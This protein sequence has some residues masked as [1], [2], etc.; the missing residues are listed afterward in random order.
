VTVALW[1]P[2]AWPGWPCDAQHQALIDA[3]PYAANDGERRQILERLHESAYRLV[4][5][6]PYG[7]W[8]LPSAIRPQLEGVLAMPGI[9][10][11]WNVKKPIR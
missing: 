8:Y 3:F 5:Y 2:G 7:Q 11:A 1:Q 9:I 6:V 4:P 10:I